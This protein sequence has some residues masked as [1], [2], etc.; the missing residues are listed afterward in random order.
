MVTSLVH[1]QWPVG[2]RALGHLCAITGAGGR[3]RCTPF[4]TGGG[5]RAVCSNWYVPSVR[6][7]YHS[8]NTIVLV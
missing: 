7:D 1:K 3:D 2:D 8:P 5:G 4:S 6:S